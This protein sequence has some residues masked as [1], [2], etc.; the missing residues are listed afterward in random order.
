MHWHQ[1]KSHLTTCTLFELSGNP[2]AGS[3]TNRCTI[4]QPLP[5]MLYLL[6]GTCYDHPEASL[7]WNLFAAVRTLA[8]LVMSM[9]ST[10]VAYKN[11]KNAS[12][13]PPLPSN[14]HVMPAFASVPNHCPESNTEHCL[15]VY[16]A[17]NFLAC[18]LKGRTLKMPH[19]HST[20]SIMHFLH[21][22]HF[23]AF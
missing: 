9:H 8:L 19:S 3:I 23:V 12:C 17:H 4:D 16:S 10:I 20:I 5:A 21:N 15:H 14:C 1:Q 22:M 18:T 13:S 2:A 11:I 6:Y 7:H